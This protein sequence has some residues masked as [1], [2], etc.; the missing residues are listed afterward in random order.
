MSTAIWS[1]DAGG[2]V[3]EHRLKISSFTC[4]IQPEPAAFADLELFFLILCGSNMCLIF[5]QE[6]G[7]IVGAATLRFKLLNAGPCHGGDMVP[8]GEDIG[9]DVELG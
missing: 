8:A 4:H 9:V 6:V 7:A 5:R 1:I 3:A 2:F